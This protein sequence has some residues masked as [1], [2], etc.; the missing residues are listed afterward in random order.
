MIESGEFGESII[1]KYKK[2]SSNYTLDEVNL[3]F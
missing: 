2:N 3:H 1:D